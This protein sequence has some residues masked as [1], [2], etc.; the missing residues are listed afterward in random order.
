MGEAAR[1]KRRPPDPDT[2]PLAPVFE[3]IKPEL[4]NQTAAE[5]A[6][7]DYHLADRILNNGYRARRRAEAAVA[8]YIETQVVDYVPRNYDE[9]KEQERY[10]TLTHSM[11]RCRRE[12]T[13]GV[14]DERLVIVWKHK[15]GCLHLCPDEAR[16]EQDR[17]KERYVPVQERL[18][19]QGWNPYKLTI[20]PGNFPTGQ[21]AWAQKYLMKR[22]DAFRRA[23]HRDQIE[24]NDATKKW[25]RFWL[26]YHRKNF[27]EHPEHPR[28]LMFPQ[29]RTALITMESPY[30]RHGDWNVHL[31]V[32]LLCQGELNYA[33]VRRW[34]R[35]QVQIDDWISMKQKTRAKLRA[36]GVD[37]KSL[38]T[39]E[40]LRHALQEIV[41]Y[42]VQTVPEKSLSG[43]S[44]GAGDRGSWDPDSGLYRDA[45][46]HIA[47][48]PLTEWPREA[49][50]EWFEAQRRFHRTRSYGELH[51]LKPAK[52]EGLTLA[53]FKE[54]FQ[55]RGFVR[56][57]GNRYLISIAGA[58]P[59][60][61]PPGY[62]VKRP[63][64]KTGPPGPEH[65]ALVAQVMASA[66]YHWENNLP[67]V[68]N[69]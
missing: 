7:G 50:I 39:D 17:L 11:R 64:S 49:F 42:P 29:A 4:L 23:R 48:P 30:S 24:G 16:E 68:S 26:R 36:R 66:R 10:E 67:Y 15:C 20:A 8:H 62:Q 45:Q 27:G 59:T 41:K 22:W 34:W 55:R 1:K 58:L 47:T 9:L 3:P 6:V 51:G 54:R 38:T 31:N 43:G 57:N 69:F 65:D 60:F 14:L 19:K 37:T 53:E 25:R 5:T 32:F 18:I 28:G 33:A 56:W 2:G 12:G 40:V 63:A 52:E 61:P 46:G 21:L 44:T 35:C 13:W